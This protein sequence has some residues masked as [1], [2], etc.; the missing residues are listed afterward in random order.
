[1]NQHIDQYCERLADVIPI[2]LFQLCYIWL[3]SRHV[4]RA[5]ALAAIALLVVFVA[6]SAF[7]AQFT[8]ILNNS[9]GYA[10]ALLMLTAFGIWHSQ[11]ASLESGSL[12]LA[13]AIFLCSLTLRTAD[14]A[15]CEM[16]PRGMH[17][18][19]HILNSIVLYLVIRAYALN[20]HQHGQARSLA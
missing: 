8:G 7:F 15:L 17:F 5:H 9:L 4:I 2:L 12:L 20:R 13:A 18:L 19:W 10:P 16:L 14:M 6:L 1:M 11:H 3:Y